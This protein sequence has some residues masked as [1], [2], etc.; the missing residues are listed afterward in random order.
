[1]RKRFPFRKRL[2]DGETETL[3]KEENLKKIQETIDSG[4]GRP[5]GSRGEDPG[6]SLRRKTPAW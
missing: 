1:M 5:E 3:E 6:C 2:E 4:A